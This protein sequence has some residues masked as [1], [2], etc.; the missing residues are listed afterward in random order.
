MEN[1][2]G[3]IDMIE[4]SFFSGRL[5]NCMFQYSFGRCLAHELELEYYVPKGTEITGFPIINNQSLHLN[6]DSHLQKYYTN[7]KQINLKT[8]EKENDNIIWFV[9]PQFNGRKSNSYKDNITL[10]HILSTPQIKKKYII[11]CGN[12]EIGHQYLKYRDLIKQWF[13]FPSID[14]TKIEFFTIHPNLGQNNNFYVRTEPDIISID[15]NDLL[16][17]L[18]LEDYTHNNNKDRLLT[19]DYFKL[20]LNYKKWKNIYIITNPSSIGHNA[21]YEYIKEFYLHNP[22]MI[23]CYDPVMSMAFSSRFKNIAISQSTYSWW[24][25]FLSDATKVFFPITINGPFSLSDNNY[26]C[27]D[28]RVSSKEFIYVDYQ[29]KTI[30]PNNFYQQIDYINKKWL[31]N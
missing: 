8:I 30:L 21:E 15:D 1:S 6:K 29:S 14:L 24:T 22:I 19:Y 7:N 13:Y 28:L 23:R 17:S 11:L 18:R 3:S 26:F 16:I 9:E 5:G 10:D 25:A 4:L 12:F 20:I 27:T 2:Y 31:P